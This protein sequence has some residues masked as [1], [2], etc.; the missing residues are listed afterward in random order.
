MWNTADF[1][2]GYSSIGIFN[3]A[4]FCGPR[5]T[6]TEDSI[7]RKQQGLHV[8]YKKFVLNMY[9]VQDTIYQAQYSPGISHFWHLH[10]QRGYISSA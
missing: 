10:A 3:L 2:K 1:G 8:Q 5:T 4:L 7:E 9:Q 6:L